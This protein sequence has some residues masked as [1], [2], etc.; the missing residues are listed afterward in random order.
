MAELRVSDWN[1]LKSE[2]LRWSELLDFS[3]PAHQLA[4]D[5]VY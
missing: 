4:T 5:R 3:P 2:L 1:S